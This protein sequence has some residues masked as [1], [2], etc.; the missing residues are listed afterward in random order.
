MKYLF[1]DKENGRLQE[2][3]TRCYSNEAIDNILFVEGSGNLL[4][5]AYSE[6]ANNH[7][8]NLVVFV[9]TIY[10][11]EETIKT[12]NALTIFAQM[13]KD[14]GCPRVMIMPIVCAEHYMIK[15]L[16]ELGVIG[17][18]GL[19]YWICSRLLDWRKYDIDGEIRRVDKVINFEHYCKAYMKYIAPDC[20]KLSLERTSTG[21]VT[22][23]YYTSD[24][25]C[26]YKCRRRISIALEQKSA[27]YV[28]QYP[29]FPNGVI[30]NLLSKKTVLNFEDMIEINHSLCEALNSRIGKNKSLALPIFSCTSEELQGKW[31][32]NHMRKRIKKIKQK[33]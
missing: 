31:E 33:A 23:K 28:T 21:S 17:T 29:C 10:D 7:D 1:E 8:E 30:P 14:N 18:H 11:N 19:I 20:A 15:S 16:G 26:E 6:L 22:G 4:K 9:D 5:V 24:C 32:R 27:S 13:C 12:Y 25:Q 2:L 3:F